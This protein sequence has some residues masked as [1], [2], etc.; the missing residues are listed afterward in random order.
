MRKSG[1]C[2]RS[3]LITPICYPRIAASRG[4][5]LLQT[6]SFTAKFVVFAVLMG[7]VERFSSICF[8]SPAKPLQYV[9]RAIHLRAPCIQMCNFTRHLT[10]AGATVTSPQK[11]PPKHE[12]RSAKLFCRNDMSI[13]IIRISFFCVCCSAFAIS[14]TQRVTKTMANL[15]TVV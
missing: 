15:L 8:T 4:Y 9:L 12:S 14:R 5:S 11:V 7:P 10:A 2:E 13:C 3:I 1:A 6:I